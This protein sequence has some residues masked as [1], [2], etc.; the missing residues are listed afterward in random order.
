MAPDSLT[1]SQRA[2]K[3]LIL[4]SE[5]RTM[6]HSEEGTTAEGKSGFLQP[7]DGC[8]PLSPSLTASSSYFDPV[9]VSKISDK[10][11]TVQGPS[12]SKESKWGTWLSAACQKKGKEAKRPELEK[13]D[14]AF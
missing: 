2:G 12:S 3:R 5:Q 7:R 1:G 9:D 14:K 13:Y 8:D 4:E 10:E 6:G 11:C